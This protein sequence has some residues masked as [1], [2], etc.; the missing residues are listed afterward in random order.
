MSV[1]KQPGSP[2]VLP[3]SVA[4]LLAAVGLVLNLVVS[5]WKY[6][7]GRH[8]WT[9]T[10]AT[11]TAGALF[12]IG[13][14]V[15]HARRPENRAGLMMILV[16]IGLALED[17]QFAETG[18]LYVAG[19]LLTAASNGP[20]AHLILAYPTGRLTSRARRIVVA[21]AYATTL[22]TILIRL[23]FFDDPDFPDWIPIFPE[24]E[25]H[26]ALNDGIGTANAVLSAAS[27]L[28]LLARFVR[29]DHFVRTLVGPVVL[30][31][32]LGALATV[33][34]PVPRFTV[35]NAI[36]AWVYRASTVLWPIVFLIG[37]LRLEW[38]LA[39]VRER[40]QARRRFQR[41]LH[42]GAQQQLINAALQLRLAA[43]RL[44]A[45][46]DEE[47]AELLAQSTAAVRAAVRELRDF[48]EGGSP[49]LAEFGLRRA[50]E[51]LVL[52]SP[53]QVELQA[54]DL[55]EPPT[56]VALQ[57]YFVTAEGLTNVLKHAGTDRASVELIATRNR[58]TVTVRDPGLGG[59]DPRGNGLAGLVE[60]VT[61][62]GGHLRI[63]SEPGTGTTLTARFP[64]P[65]QREEIDLPRS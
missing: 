6:N 7:S 13:G 3:L 30:V 52:R 11:A 43:G 1:A 22:L 4:A 16:G 10:A 55:P 61:E 58:L 56:H 20:T 32:V 41:D 48:S 14:F 17:L 29:G 33:L 42:D 25:L 19:V 35:Y 51:M 2:R 49:M 37:F 27:L 31:G 46:G 38:R 34:T 24:H 9:D 65:D 54:A 62:A 12:L 45:R 26:M 40:L 44:R 39:L 23:L 36:L 28:L 5:T 50:I 15:V 59:A 63:D 53:L 18:P 8:S 47:G 60:R 21:A 57:A 64:L